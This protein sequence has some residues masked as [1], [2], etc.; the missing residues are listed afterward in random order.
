MINP[1][2]YVDRMLAKFCQ[3]LIGHISEAV[4]VNWSIFAPAIKQY[5]ILVGV[6]LPKIANLYMGT[7]NPFEHLENYVMHIALNPNH[8]V[9]KCRL[10]R[11]TLG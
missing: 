6:K 10:F 3:Q 7:T 5:E 8:D 4:V 2:A 11:I 9:L 1:N